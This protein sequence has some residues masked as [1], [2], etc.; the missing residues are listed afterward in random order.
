[1]STP[2]LARS[3]ADPLLRT[4]ED[5]FDQAEPCGTDRAVNR[6]LIAWVHHRGRHRRQAAAGIQQ[7]LVFGVIGHG[8]CGGAGYTGLVMLHCNYDNSNARPPFFQAR[9]P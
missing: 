1:M 3:L 5:R 6:S 9:A 2:G 4:D 7:T 8:E